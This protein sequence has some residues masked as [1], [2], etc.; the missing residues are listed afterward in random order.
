MKH[1]EII[2]KEFSKQAANFGDKGLT[3]SSQH[4]LDWIVDGL[5]LQEN[6]RVLDVAAGTG[7]LSRAIAPYVKEVIAIDIT[8]EMLDQS[9]KK[10]ARCNLSNI[11]IEEGNV[12]DLPYEDNFFDLVVSRLAIHHF[13]K[14]KIQF[15]EM[16]RVCK[17]D[18]NVG[19]IDLLS[20]QDDKEAEIY[21]HL[22]RLRDPSH[23]YAF[24]KR[25]MKKIMGQ[26]RLSITAFETRA[27]KVDFKR[28]VQM[29]GTEPDTME[30]LQTRLMQDIEEGT[31]T[32]MR[33][34]IENGSLKFLQTWAIVIGK[35][36]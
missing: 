5:P 7:H 21:N 26:A 9:R 19:V 25:Q 10:A 22:E 4:I 20:P 23:V 29:T 28:W 33:P 32:G 18:H 36:L 1:N 35:K 8:P 14:P 24:S 16:A 30:L 27:I 3:L 34:F 12:E 6:F 31:K 2:R 15:D 13:E 11:V 17:P